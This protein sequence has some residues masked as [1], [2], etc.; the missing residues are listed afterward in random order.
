[1]E[2]MKKQHAAR[3]DKMQKLM[4]ELQGESEAA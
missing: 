3:V 2:Q 4:K 1:M